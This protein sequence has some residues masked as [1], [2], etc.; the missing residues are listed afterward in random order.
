MRRTGHHRCPV[1][2]WLNPGPDAR[3]PSSGGTWE[4][5][6]WNV[7][8]RSCCTVDKCHGSTVVLNGNQSR[9]ADTASGQRSTAEKSAV[10][11]WSNDDAYC[12]RTC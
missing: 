5:G 3:Y 8:V 7:K 12:Y 2:T 11:I 1:S 4:Y 6:F 9:S 10:N